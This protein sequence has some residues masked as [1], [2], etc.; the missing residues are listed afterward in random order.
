MNKVSITIKNSIYFK[1][2]LFCK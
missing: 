2:K 1:K